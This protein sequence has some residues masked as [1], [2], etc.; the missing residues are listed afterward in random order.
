[1]QNQDTRRADR[2]HA[3][4]MRNERRF[5]DVAFAARLVNEQLEQI[6]TKHP[7]WPALRDTQARACDQMEHLSRRSIKLARAEVA[8]RTGV[9]E[10]A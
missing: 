8:A 2:L 10:H 9:T 4:F 3:L 5:L 7:S 1:M 6:T